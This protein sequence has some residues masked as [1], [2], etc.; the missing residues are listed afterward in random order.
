MSAAPPLT[1]QV[2][3]VIHGC[4]AGSTGFPLHKSTCLV[5]RVFRSGSQDYV[6]HHLPGDQGQ[7]DQPLVP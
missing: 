6:L 1:Q 2:P 3:F 7:A 4:Q 5:L